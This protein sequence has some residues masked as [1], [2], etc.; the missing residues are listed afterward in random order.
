MLYKQIRIRIRISFIA[1]YV[2]T[3][4]EFF[5]VIGAIDQQQWG[6]LALLMRLIAHPHPHQ[7]YKYSLNTNTITGVNYLFSAPLWLFR[8]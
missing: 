1:K 4:K 7:K 6:S 3:Y 8:C 5:L 2:F